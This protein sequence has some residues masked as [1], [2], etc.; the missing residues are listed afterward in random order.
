MDR[1]TFLACVGL[2]W[3]ASNLPMAIARPFSVAAQES[4]DQT[5]IAQAQ[6]VPAGSLNVKEF[7]PLISGITN[8]PRTIAANTATIQ[9]A[10][11]AI[12][13]KGGGSIYIPAGLYQVTPSDLRV[14][15][16]SSIVI[17][18][19]NITL[20]G[21]GVG[22]TIIQSR[23]NWSVINGKVVR[24]H[25]ILI[26]G[27]IDPAR[28]RKNITVK[29]LE[30]SGGTTGF[31]G[32]RTWPANP[33]NGDGWDLTHK[34]I[35]LDFNKYLDN[36][37]IDSVYVHDFKGEVIYA[38]GSGVGKVTV[39]NTKL[40]RSNGSLL[41][42]DAELTVT[43]CEFSQT[44]NAWVENAPVSPNKSYFFSNCVFKDSIANG[45]VIAQGHFPFDRKQTI[46]N[47]SFHNSTAGVCIFGGT[48]NFVIKNNKFVDCNNAL[49]TS[50]ENRNI[51]FSSNEIKGVTKLVVTANIF[52]T[53]SNV[54]IKNNHHIGANN[55]EK[56][57]CIFYF[58]NLENIVIEYNTFENC[59][60]PEQVAVIT[61]ER[62]LFRNN[63]YINVER[64]Q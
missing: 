56:I 24:G 58:D 19:D 31:T 25:G 53:L 44:A 3:V 61:N 23:S 6:S 48:S 51:E 12:G 37:I 18:Y 40:H 11:D 29:N 36:I 22:K 49:I 9:T 4:P 41:S 57:A 47:C 52:G 64:R 43:N 62:P 20:I 21:D 32:N 60:T 34:G 55:L 15:E 2:G 50:G 16:V 35:V 63:Q 26:K 7:G 28:P 38:G 13:K 14:R 59:R 42:L 27:S 45:L 30:L 10:I 33:S 46:T 17:N 8:N 54:L 1:R 5:K 39:S